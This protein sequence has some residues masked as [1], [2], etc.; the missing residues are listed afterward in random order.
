MNFNDSFSNIILSYVTEYRLVNDL[1][2]KRKL[3]EGL[4]DTLKKWSDQPVKMVSK[5]VIEKSRSVTP[6]INPFDIKWTERNKLGEV[7][8][9]KK[10]PKS[11]LVWEH[12]TPLN[13]LFE[14]LTSTISKEEIISNLENYSGVCWITRQEDDILTKSGYR[15]NRPEGW[16][17]CYEKCGIEVITIEDY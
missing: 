2:L 5:K 11:F 4:K 14:K 8:E 9:E 15:S 17:K 6:Q 10:R 13:E 1:Y 3:K 16:K 12:T 7:F